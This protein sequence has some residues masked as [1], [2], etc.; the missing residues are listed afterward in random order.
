MFKRF[1]KA[2][3]DVAKKVWEFIKKLLPK[4]PKPKEV[5]PELEEEKEEDI[6]PEEDPW[7][8]EEEKP[9][10]PEP[11][12]PKPIEPAIEDENGE[13]AL[14]Y[15]LSGVVSSGESTGFI[16]IHNTGNT[17]VIQEYFH[18]VDEL[19]KCVSCRRNN[20]V[21]H[22][23]HQSNKRIEDEDDS[24]FYLTSD[25]LSAVRL[26]RKGYSDILDRVRNEMYAKVK[27]L[28]SAYESRKSVPRSGI[29]GCVPNIQRHLMGLPDTMVNREIDPK[30]VKTIHIMYSPQAPWYVKGETFIKAGV[31][32]LAAIE[33]IE[34]SGISV[35]L[36]CILYSGERSNEAIFGVVQLKDYKHRLDTLKLCF[37]L[38]H[39]SMLRRIGF[40]FL[41]TVPGMTKDFT[42]EYGRS[43]DTHES[44][45]LYKAN[46]KCVH[47]GLDTIGNCNYDV[48]QV[49]RYIRDYAE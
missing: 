34:K 36:D 22:N 32:L 37:P 11:V 49:I 5:E 26:M 38:A 18:S 39:P 42:R 24:G 28:T 15:E 35:K 29:F 6:P 14:P 16:R 9:V 25:Y 30:K 4:K 2:V 12:E 19:L 8:P 31:V 46:T 43:L 27:K 45:G 48:E 1:V 47:V 3:K 7:E 17:R 21:M 10:E 20:D 23:M 40:K 44:S 33:L 13:E 41:E